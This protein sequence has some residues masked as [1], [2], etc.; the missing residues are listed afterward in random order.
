VHGKSDS[1]NNDP[2]NKG[3]IPS[4]VGRDDPIK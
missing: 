2:Y 3:A 1:N 4:A